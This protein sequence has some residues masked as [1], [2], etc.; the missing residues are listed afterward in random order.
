MDDAAVKAA[1]NAAGRPDGY[2]PP[3]E[4][5]EKDLADS[6]HRGRGEKQQ[7]KRHTSNQRELQ[8]FLRE[9][10]MAETQA[11]TEAPLP[12]PPLAVFSA[13]DVSQPLPTVGAWARIAGLAARPTLNGT[14]V[15]VGEWHEDRQ[16]FEARAAGVEA[17]LVRP[18]NL[19]V[20][21][22]AEAEAADAHD[23]IARA[24]ATHGWARLVG[25]ASRPEL[26]GK[27]ARLLEWR[28]AAQ[29]WSV[30]VGGV[31]NA[32]R[33][34]N[35]HAL[36]EDDAAA[37]TAE[38]A[39]RRAAA[40]AAAAAAEASRAQEEEQRLAAEQALLDAYC[41]HSHDLPISPMGFFQS[42]D[43]L[44]EHHGLFDYFSPPPD[45]ASW[46]EH[47]AVYTHTRGQRQCAAWVH[48]S[49]PFCC[50][51][52]R[53][54]CEFERQPPHNVVASVH[55]PQW[56]MCHLVEWTWESMYRIDQRLVVTRQCAVCAKPLLAR[57]CPL[58]IVS[59]YEL[60]S[61]KCAYKPCVYMNE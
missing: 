2:R 25:L 56:A 39:A 1:W 18:T 24:A 58:K 22:E 8:R 41:Q 51:G 6:R 34:T 27:V 13:M 42:R 48:V 49:Q 23:A 30:A 20:L 9:A 60:Q 31:Q 12:L 52:R 21:D 28:A 37:H 5:E 46:H 57:G 35:L 11:V 3:T 4:Q 47:W 53:G 59:W 26:N 40:E 55:D 17:V 50:V 43:A 33:T 16:R 61:H 54:Y 15:R 7:K 14:L 10:A 32:V 29:R 19:S 45:A 44:I 38:V 36:D